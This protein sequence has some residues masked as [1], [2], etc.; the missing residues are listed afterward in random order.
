MSYAVRTGV[1]PLGFQ[2][3]A[4]FD[5]FLRKVYNISQEQNGAARRPK[6]R[7]L[8]EMVFAAVPPAEYGALEGEIARLWHS[9][10]DGLL[11]V[12]QV[13]YMTEK[14]QSAEAMRGQAE[15]ENYIYFRILVGGKVCG[16]C[17]IRPEEEKLFLS[18]LYLNAECR[19]RGL[20]QRALSVVAED[21]R[22]LGL[23]AVYLTV[24][25]G[26]A[27]AIRA[28]EKF[29]FVRTGEGVTDI[30]GGYAMDDYFYEYAV[31]G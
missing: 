11:G 6:E 13:K 3:F 16:Y 31:E 1:F 4:G 17:A 26:N 7:T 28:Y 25:K 19:G 18:K 23:K 12:E 29:G 10:Y 2:P 21:A 24:N 14:F 8:E 30:G 15:R 9:A 5:I 20:G 27:R 22:R